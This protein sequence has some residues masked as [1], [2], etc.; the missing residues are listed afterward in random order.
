MGPGQR[1]A[2]LR[3]PA[4]TVGRYLCYNDYMERDPVKR[5]AKRLA[6]KKASRERCAERIAAYNKV[7][8]ET[9]ATERAAYAKTYKAG[10]AASGRAHRNRQ[11]AARH[12]C[13]I[14]AD[15]SIETYRHIMAG[16]PLCAYCPAAATV[17]DHVHPFKQGGQESEGNLVPA[18]FD[19]NAGKKAKLLT[20]W[21][22]AKVEYGRIH[23]EKV[24]AE[25]PAGRRRPRP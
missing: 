11:R 13:E 14:A 17:V 24:A 2:R 7:Y 23:N 20:E 21:E 18:C 10:T 6:A 16:A 12:G 1:R 9:H 25:P 22:W 8:R 4:Y 5:R 19:C 15:V 3:C